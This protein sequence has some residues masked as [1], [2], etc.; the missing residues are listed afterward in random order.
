MQP[1]AFEKFLFLSKQTFLLYLFIYNGDDYLS[2]KNLEG[3]VCS[4]ETFRYCWI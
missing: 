1:I 4:E 2:E 3:R